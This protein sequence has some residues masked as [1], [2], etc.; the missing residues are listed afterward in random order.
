MFTHQICIF[1]CQ[2]VSVLL[3]VS[4]DSPTIVTTMGTF[5]D[6]SGRFCTQDAQSCNDIQLHF[7][8]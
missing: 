4:T 6:E 7:A 8:F 1:M 3:S 5:T 2:F